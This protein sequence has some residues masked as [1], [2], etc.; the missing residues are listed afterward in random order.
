MEISRKLD[1][2]FDAL[3]MAATAKAEIHDSQTGASAKLTATNAT[4]VTTDATLT[5]EIKKLTV[6]IVRLKAQIKAPPGFDTGFSHVGTA[7][8]AKN[9]AGVVCPVEKGK[10]GNKGNINRLYFVNKQ[11]CATCGFEARHLPAHCPQTKEGK[12]RKVEVLAKK[13][14]EAAETFI[15]IL[16]QSRHRG[17]RY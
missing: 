8:Q 1:K 13:T 4:L 16:R 15:L 6:Q 2:L 9:S 11:H 5:A 10:R 12:K 17:R 3:A 14:A 7:Q